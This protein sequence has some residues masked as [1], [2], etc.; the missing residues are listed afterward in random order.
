MKCSSDGGGA[1]RN[2]EVFG[3]VAEVFEADTRS[4]KDG[5]MEKNVFTTHSQ[6]KITANLDAIKSNDNLF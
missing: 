3:A 4:L 5:R 6:P 1:L 2:R